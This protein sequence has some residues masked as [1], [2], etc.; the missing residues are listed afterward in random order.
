MA[1]IIACAKVKGGVGASTLVMMLGHHWQKDGVSVAFCDLDTQQQ[2]LSLRDDL[3]HV[4]ESDLSKADRLPYDLVLV[5]T[6]PFRTGQTDKLLKL[7]DFV[8]IPL[9][10]SPLDVH[11]TGW[12]IEQVQRL[13]TSCGV[14][15][16]RVKPSTGFLSEVREQI[17]DWPLLRSEVRD[18]I[19]YARAVIS[20]GGL[21]D[22]E[23]PK[24]EAEIK[25]LADEI[26]TYL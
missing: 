19:S 17:E 9:N 25:A 3:P 1:R 4:E 7:A 11:S 26:E 15:L 14:V 12:L 16:N 10:P 18:R 13:R 22:E 6:P 2:S 23:N 20:E 24:A 5:D 21:A 8:L